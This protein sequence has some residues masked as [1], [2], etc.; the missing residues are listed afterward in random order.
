MCT[1]FLERRDCAVIEPDPAATRGKVIRLTDK[2]VQARANYERLL[3]AT[4]ERWR[5]VYG[6]RRARCA[7]RRP[8]APRRRRHPRLVSPG[9]RPAP[10]PG[11]WRASVQTPETLPHYPMVLHRGGF[12]DGS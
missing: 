8:R 3:A 11:N 5:A 6:P 7:A 10:E 9:R 1:G 12:P 4:E 2:G